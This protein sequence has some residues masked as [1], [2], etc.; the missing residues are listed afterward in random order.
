M[1]VFQIGKP[2]FRRR[3]AF[4]R[5]QRHFT[6]RTLKNMSTVFTSFFRCSHR[7]SYYKAVRVGGGMGPVRNPVLSHRVRLSNLCGSPRSSSESRRPLDVISVCTRSG[8]LVTDRI[9]P[10]QP[11]VPGAEFGSPDGWYQIPRWAGGWVLHQPPW[12]FGV[13]EGGREP[14][15]PAHTCIHLLSKKWA[16]SPGMGCKT[17]RCF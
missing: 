11:Q 3:S 14:L 13:G 6:V 9:G 15:P 17:L 10:Y 4:D 2:C 5:V 16:N 1:C 12:G 7:F 8:Q